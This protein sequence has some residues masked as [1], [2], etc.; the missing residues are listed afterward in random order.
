MKRFI[1]PLIFALLIL[2]ACAPVQEQVT[3]GLQNLPEEGVSLVFIVLT[4]AVVWV[5]LKLKDF[6]KI[7]L[8]GY[9]NA[10]AAALAPLLVTFIEQYL[11][12]IPP[13]FD[14]IVIAVIHNLFLLVGGLGVIW[15]AQRKPAPSLK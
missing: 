4:A 11:K 12:L 15:L 10:I 13:I 5:L 2:T 1:I 9:A 8:S 7:D 3:A 14:G 6:F